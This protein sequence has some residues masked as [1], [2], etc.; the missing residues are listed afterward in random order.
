MKGRLENDIKNQQTAEAM[1]AEMPPEVREWYYSLSVSMEPRSCLTYLRYVRM[2]LKFV[3]SPATTKNI[4]DV[5]VQ[6]FMKSIE[7]TEEHGEIRQTSFS[8]RQVVYSALARFFDF[9]VKKHWI[10]ESPM[11][12]VR[13]A[14]QKDAVKRVRLTEEDLQKILCVANAERK[15]E[16]QNITRL[17]DVAILRVFIATGIRETALCEINVDDLDF[18]KRTLTVIDKGNKRHVH[19]LGGKAMSAIQDWL[20]VRELFIKGT[21][22]GALFLTKYGT[23][24]IASGVYDIVQGYTQKALGKKLSPHK[25]RAAYATVLYD[26]TKDIRLVQDRMGHT[27][28]TTTQ[29]YVVA[30]DT[31]AAKAAQIMDI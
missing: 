17:R 23:R 16:W 15:T 19:I 9:S 26:K 7:T 14:R 1:I 25:L 18:D 2:L 10:E 21:D 31:G 27:S 22:G 28:V 24:M 6:R 12:F 30:D 13:R 11:V 5:D 8:Y 3:G 29:L 20:S 4:T